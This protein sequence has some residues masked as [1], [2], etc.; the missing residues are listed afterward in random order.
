MKTPILRLVTALAVCLGSS[1]TFAQ[2][3]NS[4][5]LK[6]NQTLGYG[7]NHQVLFTYTQSFACVDQPT[8]DLNFNGIPAASDPAEFQIPICQ[9]GIQ[10][11]V[12]PNGLHGGGNDPTEPL[13]VLVPM[14]STDNDQNPD[15]AMSCVGVVP[16]TN[17]GPA[18]GSTLIQLFGALPEAFKAKPSVYT[19][20]PDPGLPAG[21]CTMHAS[22]LDLGLA[23]E[24]LGL[25]PPPPANYFVPS[26]NH[27]HLLLSIDLNLPAIWWEVVPVLVF[28]AN[29]WP[30]QE[31][32]S[33]ITSYE[34]LL[35]AEKTG[36]AVQ[37]PS[38]FFLFF[39]TQAMQHQH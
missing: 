19:Q 10:P 30:N 32:S 29:D 8:D 5:S 38:N 27:S 37:V 1:A 26:P 33:G 15:D 36:D 7:A 34:Q 22:R 24:Q 9:A 35:A 23:L 31:G 4:Q 12:D 14:F 25:L 28:N 39:K 16:G 20:C 13:F 21:T 3:T 2:T 17:C 6:P 18:L 11:T